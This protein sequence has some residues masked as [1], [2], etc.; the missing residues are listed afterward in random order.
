MRISSKVG[1]SKRL[2]GGYRSTEPIPIYV[3]KVKTMS[4]LKKLAELERTDPDGVK[5]LRQ[6]YAEANDPSKG[7]ET[8]AACASVV[9]RVSN[10]LLLGSLREGIAENARPDTPP[11]PV[12][13]IRYIR[14]AKV[15]VRAS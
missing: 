12:Y 5:L 8:R 2:A 10:E 14:G 1:Y 6:L 11:E 4:F 7:A 9:M 15:R 13:E 3:K